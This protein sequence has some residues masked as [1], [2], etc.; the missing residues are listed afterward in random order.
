MILSEVADPECVPRTPNTISY[1]YLKVG[2][3]RHEL[4]PLPFKRKVGA[5]LRI[6]FVDG[7]DFEIVGAKP[8]IELLGTPIYLEDFP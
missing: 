6:T 7:T 2:G 1:G 3:I 5:V 4:I 8:F